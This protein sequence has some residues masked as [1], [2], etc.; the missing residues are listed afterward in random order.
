M[1][2]KKVCTKNLLLSSIFTLLAGV[3]TTAQVNLITDGGFEDTLT[4]WKTQLIPVNNQ[5]KN[6]E[7]FYGVADSS[8]AYL[9][10]GALLS[11]AIQNQ[12]YS[13]PNSVFSVSVRTGL[14]CQEMLSH[15]ERQPSNGF[16][17]SYSNMRTPIRTKLKQKLTAGKTYCGTFWVANQVRTVYYNTNGM[18][19]YF[20]NGR[21]DTVITKLGDTSMQFGK[22][23]Q[24]QIINYDVIHDSANYTK[25]Q[26]SFV[27]NGTET[28]V[29]IGNCL[30]DSTQTKVING[31]AALQCPECKFS[32]VVIDDASVIPIDISNWLR[33]T[34]C[35]LGDSVWVGLSPLDYG[36]GKWYTSTMQYIS[37]GQGFWFT[38]TQAT[39]QFIQSIDVCGAVLYDTMHVNAWPLGMANNPTKNNLLTVQPNP[40]TK[41]LVLSSAAALQGVVKVFDIHGKLLLSHN[42]SAATNAITLDAGSLAKGF[43][44]LRCNAGVVRFTTE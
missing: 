4:A 18:G 13:I 23:A 35:N 27:A 2:S 25:V 12:A 34:F 15:Y 24:A 44:I 39:T 37:T 1:R 19:M 33:D 20:D 28:Y 8:S 40:V 42:I 21:L 22:Y 38:P 7:F 26:G 36:D 17:W 16:F 6:W 29:T 3:R 10:F 43:Y 32:E 14:H 31:P 11:S 41:S 5:L 9:G 30:T